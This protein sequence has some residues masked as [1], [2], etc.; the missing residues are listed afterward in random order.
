MLQ[1]STEFKDFMCPPCAMRN[2]K[3]TYQKPLTN[4]P[5]NRQPN[6]IW[7]NPPFN[8]NVSTNVAQALLRLIDKH[9]PKPNKLHKIFNRNTVKVS[10]SCTES[11][12]RIINSHNKTIIC[13]LNRETLPCNCRNKDTCPLD[14]KCRSRNVIYKCKTNPTDKVYIGLTS[15]EF[16]ERHGGHMKSFRNEKYSTETTLSKHYWEVKNQTKQNLT[17]QWSLLRF[18]P[19]YSNVSKKCPLCL[20]EKFEIL[21][22]ERPEELLNKRSEII[23]KCRH[24]NKYLL[25]DFKKRHKT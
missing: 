17:L 24:Q 25:K 9:F 19:S 16:K 10:Y 6:I 5:K 13:P 2:V 12:G 20:H 22:Y 7:F 21:H 1:T 23:F 18:V 4:K 11:M 3:L 14:G 15:R 8:K